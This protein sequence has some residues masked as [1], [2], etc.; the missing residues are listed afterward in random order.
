MVMLYIE[1]QLPFPFVQV[2]PRHYSQP[3]IVRTSLIFR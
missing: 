1:V 3:S 2:G